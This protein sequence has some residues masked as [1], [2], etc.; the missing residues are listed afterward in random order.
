MAPR[1]NA[2][3]DDQSIGVSMTSF[4]PRPMRFSAADLNIAFLTDPDS[5]RLMGLRYG[6]RDLLGIEASLP[7]IEDR[8]RHFSLLEVLEVLG[9]MNAVLRS[10]TASAVEAQVSLLYA[11]FPERRVRD[12]MRRLEAT[13]RAD[14]A[15]SPGQGSS[16][17]AIFE[18]RLMAAMAV[19]AG[20]TLPPAGEQTGAPLEMIGEALMMLNDLVDT[21]HSPV[22]VDPTTPEGRLQWVHYFAVMAF[23]RGEDSTVEAMVRTAE[24][25]LV[26]HDELHDDPDYVDLAT[27]FEEATGLTLDAYFLVSV[28]LIG[29]M[30]GITAED[31]ASQRALIPS[32]FFSGFSAAMRT[33][34]LSLV[35]HDSATFCRDAARAWPKGELRPLKILPVEL[36][37]IVHFGEGHVCLSVQLLERR[38]T[39]GIYHVLLNARPGPADR[40]FRER[41]QRFIGRAFEKYVERAALR[42]VEHLV[43]QRG[44]HP[45]DRRGGGPARF[46]TEEALRAALVPAPAQTPSIC[47]G[48]L[49]VGQDLFLIECKA[50]FFSLAERTG[51]AP[52]SLTKRLREITVRGTRQLNATLALIAAGRFREL[53]LVPGRIRRVFP[54][55]ISLEELPLSA[56][57]RSWVDDELA[58]NGVLPDDMVGSMRVFAPE[59][60]SARDLEWLEAVV[61]HTG[62]RP[63]DLVVQKQSR[64]F[65]HGISFI[66]WGRLAKVL[67]DRGGATMVTYH[68]RRWEELTDRMR[69]F[70]RAQTANIAARDERGD[71]VSAADAFLAE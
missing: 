60:L 54:V 31:A 64:P 23:I 43:A 59:Y 49:L 51:D 18:P 27:L 58:A 9:R 25:F 46:F 68:R 19:L 42:I 44:W 52:D 69:A 17:P 61:E 57:V 70:F 67:P 63:G 10:T 12:I 37:P 1:V 71:A 36:S 34:F 29:K 38:L 7:A 22:D 62:R 56:V 32:G 16:L 39:T 40:S 15:E 55:V 8:L 65:W 3:L 47:D 13:M 5:Q 53:G 35:G 28:A 30:F 50:R 21:V 66:S 33:R 14:A 11:L 45:R 24:I 20:A 48:A 26:H 6:A 2:C 4:P 41:Y